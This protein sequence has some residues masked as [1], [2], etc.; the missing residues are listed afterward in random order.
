MGNIE[1]SPLCTPMILSS[2]IVLVFCA[3]LAG[4]GGG[5]HRA[6]L[7]FEENH[8]AVVEI[9]GAEPGQGKQAVE[10]HVRAMLSKSEAARCFVRPA[11]NEFFPADALVVD[12]SDAEA[13]KAPKNEPRSACRQY[14][15]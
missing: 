10:G 15:G 1:D 5:A 2:R 9:W 6:E 8:P 13:A 14:V 4:C 7:K 3:F 11:R 12:V